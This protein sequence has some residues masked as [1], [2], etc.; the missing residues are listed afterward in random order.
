MAHERVSVVSHIASDGIL[1]DVSPRRLCAIIIASGSACSILVRERYFGF[2]ERFFMGNFFQKIIPK[3]K[4]THF[5]ENSVEQEA[6]AR[7]GIVATIQPSFLEEIPPLHYFSDY[8][9]IYQG[10]EYRTHAYIHAREGRKDEYGLPTIHRVSLFVPDVLF[11]VFGVSSSLRIP[12]VWYHGHI[13]NDDFNALIQK[14]QSGL[15]FN[16]F[17][18]FSE[19]TAKSVLMGQY[20]ITM[21][22]QYPY[23]DFAQ[24]E[25][26]LI[27]L[28]QQLKN[29]KEPN[30]AARDFWIE[31]ISEFSFNVF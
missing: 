20:P 30:Y 6:L 14:Y 26:K 17:D 11:H 10:R 23:I 1:R 22:I 28:L 25:N 12:N 29:K 7:L 2:A 13:S 18:G 31:K 5:C 8:P 19:I 27:A 16:R 3:I 21:H 15:R 9:I 4:A 24:D